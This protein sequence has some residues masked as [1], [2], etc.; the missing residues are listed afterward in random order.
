MKS[1]TPLLAQ[2]VLT[3]ILVV[4][5]SSAIACNCQCIRK[6]DRYKPVDRE[7]PDYSACISACRVAARV[8]G[9]V[10]IGGNCEREASPEPTQP[11]GPPGPRDCRPDDPHAWCEWG[12]DVRSTIPNCY[13]A[14]PPGAHKGVNVTINRGDVLRS[15]V[16]DLPLTFKPIGTSCVISEHRHAP[17]Y[18]R[19][20]LGGGPGP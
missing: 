11:P 20:G 3:L 7:V 12:V 10:R 19:R 13:G 14:F 6:S 15:C 16:K 18:C 9:P 17:E 8:S 4:I 1:T 5:S 2:F